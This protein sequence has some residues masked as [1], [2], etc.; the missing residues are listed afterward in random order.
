MVYPE[1]Y[2]DQ[3]RGL[4]LFPCKPCRDQKALDGYVQAKIARQIDQPLNEVENNLKEEIVQVQKTTM[5]SLSKKI[6]DMETEMKKTISDSVQQMNEKI[7]TMQP[8]TEGKIESMQVQVNQQIE[9]MTAQ[10]NNKF[11]TE[12]NGIIQN[13]AKMES[14]SEMQRMQVEKIEALEQ[15]MQKMSS[16]MQFVNDYKR[17]MQDVRN[18]LFGLLGNF[19]GQNRNSVPQNMSPFQAPAQNQPGMSPVVP[20]I[21]RIA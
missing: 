8:Q 21:R 12:M 6:E 1:Y 4:G 17:E 16:E 18:Q 19:S 9:A 3:T 2:V 14:E 10:I 11:Q 15:N 5:T 13:I 20:I 7:Q